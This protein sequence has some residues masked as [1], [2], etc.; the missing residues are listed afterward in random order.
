MSRFLFPVPVALLTIIVGC[1]QGTKPGSAKPA[2]GDFGGATVP[3]TEA[4]VK[5]AVADYVDLAKGFYFTKAKSVTLLTPPAPA[6]DKVYET[7]GSL[8]KS[9]VACYAQIECEPRPGS[10]T[11]SKH[12]N[13]IVVGRNNGKTFSADKGKLSVPVCVYVNSGQKGAVVPVMGNAWASANLPPELP[14]DK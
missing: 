6:P 7:F 1:S 10:A 11:G 13:L 5:K 14:K 4:D 2:G 12:F 9:V 3:I 8:E